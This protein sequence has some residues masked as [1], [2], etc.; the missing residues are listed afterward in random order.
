MTAPRPLRNPPIVEA[1][2]DFRVKARQGFDSQEFARIK[3]TLGDRFP[4]L[5]QRRE[6]KVTFQF[7]PTGMKPPIIED[8]GLQGFV[9]KSADQKLLVQFR[10]DGFTLNR[11]KP[12]PGWEEI[13]PTALELWKLYCSVAIPDGVTRLALR[14]INRINLPPDP[15]EFGRYMRAAPE[16]PR[17]LPQE[18]RAFFTRITIVDSQRDL[19]AHISQSLGLD[20]R[21]Q[22]TLLLD[23]DAFREGSWAPLDPEIERSFQSLREFKNLIFFNS[24]T[25][26]ALGEFQ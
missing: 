24:L 25:E 19:A 11:L 8:L 4:K 14:Y 16:V 3:P 17:E 13:F 23:V 1:I 5:D 9:F 10:A 12:Y 22:T 15:G 20:S 7:A 26:E 21:S 2:I 6:G 18:V